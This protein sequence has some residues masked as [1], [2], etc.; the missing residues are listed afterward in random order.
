MLDNQMRSSV[1]VLQTPG[2]HSEH[3][4]YEYDLPKKIGPQ[5]LRE[6]TQQVKAR[7]GSI[8]VSLKLFSAQIQL[9]TGSW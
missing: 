5:K 1:T 4:K 8:L 3:L 9:L 7:L 2:F 6:K